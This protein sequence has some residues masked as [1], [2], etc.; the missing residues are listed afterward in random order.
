LQSS[1]ADERLMSQVEF[2]DSVAQTCGHSV[3]FFFGGGECGTKSTVTEATTGLLYQP[4]RIMADD[5][6]SSRWNARQRKPK[7]S[8]KTCPSA[9]LASTNPCDLTR[10][11]LGQA[12]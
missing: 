1:A 4:W 12:G 9:T 3:F 8:E 2:S 7:Y 6:W 10:L 5:E 11:E